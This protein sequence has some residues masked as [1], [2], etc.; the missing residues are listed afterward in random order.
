[1]S[2]FVSQH[3]FQDLW[4]PYYKGAG[5]P[6]IAQ[7]VI[8][9]A[10]FGS[11]SSRGRGAAEAGGKARLARIVNKA[12]EV[13]VKV[14]GRTRDAVHLRAHLEYISRNGKIELETSE[15]QRI[16]GGP[17]V[18][19]LAGEWADLNVAHSNGGVNASYKGTQSTSIVLSMPPGTDQLRLRDAARAFAGE[20]FGRYDYVMALHAD[21]SHPH[22]HLTVRNVGSDL[23]RLQIGKGDLHDMRE[24]F[25]E[26]LRERGVQA[27]AT[28]RVARG[29]EGRAEHPGLNRV[30][31]RYEKG[32][33]PMPTS[34]L[35]DYRRAA[36]D[37]H[38]RPG[39][40]PRPHSKTERVME[41]RQ[42]EIRGRYTSAARAL[43]VSSDPADRALARQVERFVEEMPRPMDRHRRYVEE[44]KAA[45]TV[46]A[47]EDASQHAATVRHGFASEPLVEPLPASPEDSG[48][49][50]GRGPA[51]KPTSKGDR[52]R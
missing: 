16:N 17:H 51:P 47:R 21:T 14:T 50:E 27:E 31:T 5:K 32:E 44:L 43:A 48:R 33:G 39:Y 9:A 11:G 30:R 29:L 45:E 46:L 10:H 4:S 40:R 49:G 25:A 26:K 8:P 1:M 28:P 41:A 18:R 15:S 24:L 37:D 22:V 42:S 36:N 19:V 12:S 3:G 7:P 6:K 2:D 38:S 23:K 35:D 20:M 52:E 34:A 13:T